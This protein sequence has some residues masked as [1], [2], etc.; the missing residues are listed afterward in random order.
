MEGT[1][2]DKAGGASGKGQW[3][4][5]RSL[6]WPPEGVEAKPDAAGGEGPGPIPPFELAPDPDG[7]G[8]LVAVPVPERPPVIE[9]AALPESP[10]L[11]PAPTLAPASRVQEPTPV[12]S[13]PAETP[14]GPDGACQASLI[15]AELRALRGA[16]EALTAAIVGTGAGGG[17]RV[18]PGT[19]IVPVRTLS[20][21]QARAE[22]QEYFLR[23]QGETLYP[24]QIA[25]AL[26]LPVLKVAEL[27]ETLALR[28]QISRNLVS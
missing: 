27:C 5:M 7:T 6:R 22:I 21:H 13:A 10:A 8:T 11:S 19:G 17:V 14:V 18:A 24:A 9:V 4:D 12:K 26:N 3:P 1:V 25:D 2:T 28:G 23:H 16:V 15:V 20:D